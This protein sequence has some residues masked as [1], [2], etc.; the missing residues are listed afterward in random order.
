MNLMTMQTKLEQLSKRLE[1]KSDTSELKQKLYDI[2]MSHC[3]FSLEQV[4]KMSYF[5]QMWHLGKLK[6]AEHSHPSEGQVTFST[7]AEYKAWLNG[8]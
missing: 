5:Q 8:R 4:I 6:A 2:L 3:G 7:V 1:G